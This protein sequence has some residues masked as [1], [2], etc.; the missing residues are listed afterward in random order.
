MGFTSKAKV[1]GGGR[2]KKALISAFA[3]F[4]VIVGAFATYTYADDNVPDFFSDPGGAIAQA[5]NLVT[6][7]AVNN[8]TWEVDP[9]TADD[10]YND[11]TEA[12][13]AGGKDVLSSRNVGRV[14]TDKTVFGSQA[15]LTNHENNQKITVTND[16]PNSALVALSALSSTMTIEG[17]T[18]IEPLDIV[19]VL[20]TSNGM[21]DTMNSFAYSAEYSPQPGETYYVETDNGVYEAVTHNGT[22]W[23]N[24]EGDVFVPK[25]SEGDTTEGGRCIPRADPDEPAEDGR[26]ERRCDQLHQSDRICQ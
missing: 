18:E 22:A 15:V 16:D 13:E 3:T 24:D 5:F 4:M 19:L 20:D 14:W 23:V 21:N 1:S 9:S 6:G 10:W 2:F 25:K 17:E 12:D 7:R 8:A 11:L 26:A